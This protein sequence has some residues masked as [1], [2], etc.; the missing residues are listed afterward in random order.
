MATKAKG[1]KG[2]M[3]IVPLTTT[4]ANDKIAPVTGADTAIDLDSVLI[5]GVTFPGQDESAVEYFENEIG[6]DVTIRYPRNKKVYDL[7][8]EALATSADG[9]QSKVSFKAY[10]T[11]A[12]QQAIQGLVG[13]LC[14]VMFFLEDTTGTVKLEFHLSAAF[15]GDI[16]F[17]PENGLL[18]IENE[19][20]GK[21]ITVDGGST[22]T[23]AEYNTE[24]VTGNITP[25]GDNAITPTAIVADDFTKLLTGQFAVI[26]T[27]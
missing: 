22:V 5:S 4:D 23:F 2:G 24:V 12:Q 25:S 1:F 10:L 26:E 16:E 13:R 6:G 9:S 8:T 11:V 18:K 14:S 7:V 17:S 20:I 21:A 3:R 27:A 15:S 19:F